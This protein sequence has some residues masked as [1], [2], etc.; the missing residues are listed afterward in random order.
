M[1]VRQLP[2]NQFFTCS[3]GVGSIFLIQKWKSSK[4]LVD[5]ID[6]IF[7]DEEVVIIYG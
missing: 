1:A 6:K 4:K 3:R 2:N 7:P 5:A